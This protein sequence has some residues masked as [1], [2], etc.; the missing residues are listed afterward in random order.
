MHRSYLSYLSE[1]EE[2]NFALYKSVWTLWNLCPSGIDTGKVATDK[3]IVSKE[4]LFTYCLWDEHFHTDKLS[5]TTGF[6]CNVTFVI[7][8]ARCIFIWYIFR[9]IDIFVCTPNSPM[10]LIY[11]RSSSRSIFAPAFKHTAVN[12]MNDWVHLAAMLSRYVIS[13]AWNC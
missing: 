11:S 4:H 5:H 9:C 12:K 7:C 1:Q 2:L 8:A 3:Y 6:P 10:N 13:L